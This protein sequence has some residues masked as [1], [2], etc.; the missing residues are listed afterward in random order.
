MPPKRILVI[1]DDLAIADFAEMVL[2]KD[3]FEVQQ[4]NDG[5]AGVEKA[6]AFRPHL[7]VLDLMLP[8]LHGFEVARI[9][10]QEKDLNGLEILVTSAKISPDDFG[11]AETAGATEFLPKP[12]GASDLSKRVRRMIGSAREEGT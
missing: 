8:E 5:K 2:L 3:G 12:Y 6:L 7:L 9:L 11:D 1:E 10:R 4:A